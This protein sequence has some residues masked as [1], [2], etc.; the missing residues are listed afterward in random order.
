MLFR[1]IREKD[2]EEVDIYKEAGIDRKL[3]SKIRCRDDYA[4]R[5]GTVL[6]LALAMELSLDEALDLLARA[7]FTLSRSSRSDL[8]VE[9]MISEGRFDLFEVNEALYAF[10]LSPLS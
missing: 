6:S 10:G 8:I 7:G 1:L 5:K 4:P 2:L 3:F 9:Y